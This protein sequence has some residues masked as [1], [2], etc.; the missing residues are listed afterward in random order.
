M[1]NHVLLFSFLPIS[2]KLETNFYINELLAQGYNVTYLDIHEIFPV[3]TNYNCL[4]KRPY[5]I[6]VKTMKEFEERIASAQQLNTLI[7][8]VLTFNYQS[9]PFFRIISRH[10][11]KLGFFARGMVPIPSIREKLLQ[12]LILNLRRYLDYKKILTFAQDR[13]ALLYKSF[14]LIKKYDVVFTAG[15]YGSATIGIGGHLDVQEAK[16]I[17]INYF[18][19]DKYLRLQLSEE[20]EL[21][22]RYCVFLDQNLPYHPD[23]ELFGKQ[24]INAEKY[25]KSL[26]SF[27]DSIEKK[28]NVKVVIAAHPSASYTENPFQDRLIIKNKTAELVK[29]AEMVLAHISTSI[30]YG[31]LNNKPLI[32]FYNEEVLRL[33]RKE[34][35]QYISDAVGGY[36][37]DADDPAALDDLKEEL[38]IDEQKHAL[39]K[40]NFLTSV[41]SETRESVDI[42]INQLK[43]I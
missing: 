4:E 16:I 40:Y 37:I 38:R 24:R 17:N 30:S 26:N 27:F 34:G 18:D 6:Y 13:V 25:F 31:V 2:T 11:I 15:T 7:I 3:K 33:Y 39:Y 36:F 21:D 41:E 19:Y 22:G 35:L 32:I 28:Y 42:F 12:K 43:L 9:L 1:I 20:R 23:L 8:P 5:V 29:N 14:G 10:D